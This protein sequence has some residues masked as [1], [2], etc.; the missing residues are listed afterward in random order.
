MSKK[1]FFL[2]EN[3]PGWAVKILKNNQEIYSEYEGLANLKTQEKITSKTNFRLASISKTFTAMAILILVEQKYISIEDKLDKFFP[4][5]I[6][7]KDVKIYN[8]LNHTSG[9]PDHEK[10][11]YKILKPN[12]EPD[13]NSS[14]Q[15]LENYSKKLLFSAG[16]KFKYSDSGY[17]LLGLII[18]KVS[19][20]SYASFLKKYIF[21]PMQMNSTFVLDKTKPIISNQA[22]GYQKKGNQFTTFD[23]NPLNYIVGD[24]GVYSNLDDLSKWW[25]AWESEVLISEKTLKL[26]FQAPKLANGDF[27]RCGFSWFLNQSFVDLEMIYS[28]GSWVGFTNIFVYLPKKKIQIILLTNTNDLFNEKLKIEKVLSFLEKI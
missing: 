1:E 16:T 20:L 25:T 28:P 13:M 6:F 5:L 7:A 18:E 21:E 17:V 2:P 26:V 22:L 14:L 4:N 9:M 15:A 24:E 8:L 23:Y 19:K 12:E 11:L 27:G 10:I 3:K